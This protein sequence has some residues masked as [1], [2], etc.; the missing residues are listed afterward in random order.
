MKT[1]NGGGWLPLLLRVGVWVVIGL[2][3]V[4]L[5]LLPGK[6]VRRAELVRAFSK[7][8]DVYLACAKYASD[9]NGRFPSPQRSEGANAN[10]ALSQLL[11]YF[12]EGKAPFFVKGSIWTPGDPPR[13]EADVTPLVVGQN[14]WAYIP[15]LTIESDPN[16]PLL[17]D[18]F[19]P[20][21][22]G[23]YRAGLF[24]RAREDRGIIVVRRDG[25]GKIERP[26]EDWRLFRTTA[27]GDKQPLFEIAAGWLTPEQAPL[28]P[29]GPPGD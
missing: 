25:S 27:S 20:G 4:E 26:D 17:A 10:E 28:N 8:K 29:A 12:T 11:E 16:L 1:Q 3:V 18:G 14:H 6:E 2:F 22:P 15:H 7:A 13:H 19:A 21:R 5:L 23:V 24:S 9:H